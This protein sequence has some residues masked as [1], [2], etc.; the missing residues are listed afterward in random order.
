M[1]DDPYNRRCY[2]T[3]RLGS[4]AHAGSVPTVAGSYDIRPQLALVTPSAVLRLAVT[5][6]HNFLLTNIR[7]EG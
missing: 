6:L 5:Q 2:L 4:P 1:W 3:S 7:L